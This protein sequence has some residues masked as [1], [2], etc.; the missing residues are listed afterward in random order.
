MR[1]TTFTLTVFLLWCFSSIASEPCGLF[2]VEG[3]VLPGSEAA[4]ILNPRAVTKTKVT[5]SNPKLLTPYKGRVVRAQLWLRNLCHLQCSGTIEKILAE[6]EPFGE[7]SS[8]SRKEES[9][10]KEVKCNSK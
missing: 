9:I 3:Y 2:E 5:I 6:V 7:I 8:F 4:L 1:V 10:V